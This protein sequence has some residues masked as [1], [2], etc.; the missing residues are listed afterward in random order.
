MTVRTTRTCLVLIQLCFQNYCNNLKKIIVVI[1]QYKWIFA[2]YLSQ[3][4]LKQSLLWL[5]SHKQLISTNIRKSMFHSLVSFH[6]NPCF[7]VVYCLVQFTVDH[8]FAF[9]VLLLLLSMVP[10]N[11]CTNLVPS[12]ASPMD[13]FGQLIF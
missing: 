11:D 9:Q 8:S 2:T 10:L 1:V 6:S 5:L 12:V 7:S 4:C 13:S 3:R